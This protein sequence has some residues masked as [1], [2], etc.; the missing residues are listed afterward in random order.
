MALNVSPGEN[1]IQTALRGFLLSVLPD[2]S[3]AI[4]GQLNRVPEPSASDFVVM[5]PIRRRRFATNV[6]AF[7]DCEFTASI[8]PSSTTMTVTAVGTNNGIALRAGAQVAGPAVTA[9]TVI[10]SQ[11][12]GTPG[13]IGT[14]KVSPSQTAA[15]QTMA[16][17]GASYTQQ[18]EVVYQ[19][20]VH[21]A[22]VSDSSNMAQTISTMLRDAYGVQTIQAINA[23]VM[24][25]YASDPRQVPFINAEDQYETRWIVEALLQANQTVSGAPAQ[26]ATSADITLYDV[27]VQSPPGGDSWSDGYSDGFGG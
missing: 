25:L 24:P 2:G 18:T 23:N 6:D 19:L 13:G 15:S 7:A 11:L 22:N 17:G 14:Y 26:F 12:T 8:G 4:L 10:S 20:D 1:D 27:D 9:G 16:A 21:S 3:D 5:W